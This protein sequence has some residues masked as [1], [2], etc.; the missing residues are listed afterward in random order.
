ML[1]GSFAGAYS[2]GKAS[3]G[4]FYYKRSICIKKWKSRVNLLNHSPTKYNI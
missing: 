2:F 3:R 4:K 1:N